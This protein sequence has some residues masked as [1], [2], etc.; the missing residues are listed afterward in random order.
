MKLN[1]RRFIKLY[2]LK[3]IRLKGDPKHIARGIA[4]GTFIGVTPTIPFHTVTMII[5]A[6]LLRGNIIAAFLASVVF[7]N[8]L[9]YL[10]QYYFS[11]LIGNWLTP[12]NLSWD[13][14]SSVMTIVFSDSGYLAK[15]Q[16]LSQLGQETI[17]V[18]LVGGAIMATPIAIASYLISL[19]FFKSLR[20][21]RR[22]KHI[23]D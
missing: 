11:W 20:A 21:K 6:P 13:R 5:V 2:Y 14:I 22:K 9:T 15:F 17:I 4:I 23:L 7:C 8:P 12:E 16:A 18:L 3:F 10:P 19:R 1:I